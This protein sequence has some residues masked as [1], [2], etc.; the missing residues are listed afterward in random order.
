VVSLADETP[1]DPVGLPVVVSGGQAWAHAPEQLDLPLASATHRYSARPE[2]LVRNVP[3]EPWVTL[4]TAPEAATFVAVEEADE[5]AEAAGAADA[6]EV[7]LLL[8]LPHPAAIKAPVRTT[9]AATAGIL[10]FRKFIL[11]SQFLVFRSLEPC[12]DITNQDSGASVSLPVAGRRPYAV[13]TMTDIGD[14]QFH[15]GQAIWVVNPDGTQRAAEFVGEGELSAWF[16]GAPTVIV[17]YPDTRTGEA[18]EVN[19]VLPR[20]PDTTG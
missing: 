17:V 8:L 9:P 7:G 19:R 5:V 14:G 1:P 16:G 10:R 2:P 6:V 18:V 13:A 12:R 4:T 3:V 20:E 11:S 15:K